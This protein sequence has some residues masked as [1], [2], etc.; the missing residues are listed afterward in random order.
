[1]NSLILKFVEKFYLPKIRKFLQG[2]KTYLLLAI[3]ILANSQNLLLSVQALMDGQIDLVQFLDS[4]QNIILAFSGM[5]L[6][7]GIDRTVKKDG[8]I[9]KDPLV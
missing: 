2:K 9:K 5:T 1:M 8:E 6:K 4:V 7:A 3:Y